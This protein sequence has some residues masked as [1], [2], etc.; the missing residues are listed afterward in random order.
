MSG[1]T[2]LWMNFAKIPTDSEPLK[3][4]RKLTAAK[5]TEENCELKNLNEKIFYI[6]MFMSAYKGWGEGQCSV[7]FLAPLFN[8]A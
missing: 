8:T 3:T 6:H 1:T 7:N 4:S 5:E 2:G